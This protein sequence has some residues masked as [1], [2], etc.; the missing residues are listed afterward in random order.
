MGGQIYGKLLFRNGDEESRAKKAEI[1]NLHRVY[2]RDDMVT[3]DVIDTDAPEVGA[4]PYLQ[5][6]AP[7]EPRLLGI[8]EA[9]ACERQPSV[10]A[11]ARGRSSARRCRP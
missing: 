8:D 3:G 2:T 4:N 6:R 7:V 1:T 11:P 5:P 10:T 9:R